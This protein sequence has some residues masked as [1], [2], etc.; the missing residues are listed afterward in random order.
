MHTH[1]TL[2][3]N[4]VASV[5]KV[6]RQR[7]IPFL[8]RPPD[9][10]MIVIV[11]QIKMVLSE[12]SRWDIPWLSTVHGKVLTHKNTLD[13]ALFGNINQGFPGGYATVDAQGIYAT[14]GRYFRKK[15]ATCV[16]ETLHQYLQSGEALPRHQEMS[17]PILSACGFRVS[18]VT[19]SVKS[20][21][22]FWA[23]VA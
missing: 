15:G 10:Q 3:R 18:P 1:T 11:E 7:Q 16:R 4:T 13:P 23:P 6:E 14:L 17:T 2:N 21:G 5:Y 9:S 19:E 12:Y 8:W 22:Y 20:L